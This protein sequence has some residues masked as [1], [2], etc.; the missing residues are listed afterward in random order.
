MF[1][2]CLKVLTRYN[3][4]PNCSYAHEECPA[5]EATALLLQVTLVRWSR[6]KVDWQTDEEHI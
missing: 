3:L 2:L 1:I 5:G 6:R 4:H